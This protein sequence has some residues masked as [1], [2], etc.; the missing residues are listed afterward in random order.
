MDVRTYTG[1][2]EGQGQGVGRP[3]RL[4]VINDLSSETVLF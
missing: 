2:L 3:T 4:S 1:R